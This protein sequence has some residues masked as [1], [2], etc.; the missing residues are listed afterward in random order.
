MTNHL[1]AN[2]GIGGEINLS[3]SGY[4][5]SLS[6]PTYQ[7]YKQTNGGEYELLEEVSSNTLSYSDF[8]VD[9]ANSY[10][11]FIG[12]E[13]DVSCVAEEGGGIALE[14]HDFDDIDNVYI[15]NSMLEEGA[16]YINPTYGSSYITNTTGLKGK[17]V[18]RSSPFF[19]EAEPQPLTIEP[20]IIQSVDRIY[21]NPASQVLY[22]DLADNAGEIEKL[23]FVDFSGKVLDNVRFKQTGDKAVVD[24]ESLQSG[25]YLLDVTTKLG[26][27]RVKVII[28][29]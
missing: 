7:I 16:S 1:Q 2:Q 8:N 17:K 21:P 20:I 10:Q 11:Y 6:V 27:S 29:K 25:I 24:T 13:A 23:Y 15:P 9:P 19:L 22:I 26:H 4:E 18:I 12:F 3:W 28:Q 14:Y 5:S